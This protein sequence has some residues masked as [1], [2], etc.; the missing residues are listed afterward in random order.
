MIGIYKIISPTGKIYIG[1][2]I[3]IENRWKTYKRNDFRFQT[4]LKNSIQKYGLEKHQ[5]IILEQCDLDQLNNRERYYQDL[6]DVLGP[7]GLNCRLTTTSSKSGKNSVE[8]NLKRS[9]TTIGIKKGPRPDV[10]A[11]NKI[12]HTGKI[13]SE[14]HK[15][16][17]RARKGIKKG[18]MSE[19]HKQKLRKPKTNTAKENMSKAW[20]YKKDITC[21]HCMKISK[22]AANMKRWHFD[23]CKQKSN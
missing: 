8:S 21:P 11:R 16:A 9:L 18:P 19:E 1:Q 12:V 10:S 6:Y 5:F 22:H 15:E 3:N 14:Q 13:I 20:L 2:S 4:R 23:N 7:N 17:L